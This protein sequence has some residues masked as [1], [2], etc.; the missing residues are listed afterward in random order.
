MSLLVIKIA[1][2]KA[3]HSLPENYVKQ[4]TKY[5]L[6]FTALFS[7]ILKYEQQLNEWRDG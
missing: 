6:I 1:V 5:L 7:I 4:Q 2:F 3:I